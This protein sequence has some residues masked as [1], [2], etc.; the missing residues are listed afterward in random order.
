MKVIEAI[1]ENRMELNAI[2]RLSQ[3]YVDNVKSAHIIRIFESLVAT[4]RERLPTDILYVREL[5]NGTLDEFLGNLH[6]AGKDMTPGLFM[7][8]MVQIAHGLSY[9]HSNGIVHRDLTKFNGASS[10]LGA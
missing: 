2:S 5:C 4:T 3:Q 9:C 6:N 1:P 7:H 8:I 10:N